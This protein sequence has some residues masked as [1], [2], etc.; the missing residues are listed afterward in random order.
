M[1][2]DELVRLVEQYRAGIEAELQLLRQLAEIANRQRTET[3]TRNLAGLG[4]AA[5]E[6]DAIMRSLVMIEEG[7]RAVRQVLTEHRDVATTLPGYQDVAARHREAAHLVNDI[8]AVDQQS[9]S[10]LADA[11]LA[12]RSAMASLER[13][14]ATLAAYRRVLAPPV[15]SATLFDRR[16]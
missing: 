14:E 8:L 16:G 2:R 6:R 10:A 12:R 4:H 3:T 13:G 5:D 1:T 15:A 7:L 11:E 9:L